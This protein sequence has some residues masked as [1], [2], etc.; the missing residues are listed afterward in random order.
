M[1]KK[2]G[3]MRRQDSGPEREEGVKEAAMHRERPGGE[4]D[5]G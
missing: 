5:R 4:G 3:V 2:R 1:S